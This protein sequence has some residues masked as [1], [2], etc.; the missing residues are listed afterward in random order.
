MRT[1]SHTPST[2]S[3]VDWNLVAMAVS[4]MT[5][6]AYLLSQLG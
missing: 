6:V 2:T 1:D 3:A 4:L 5:A